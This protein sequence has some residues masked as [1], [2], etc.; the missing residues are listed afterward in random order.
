[1]PMYN[2][3]EY[4]D[5]YSIASGNLWN[6]FREE[7]DGVDNIATHGKSFK[8]K[9][10]NNYKTPVRPPQCGNPRDID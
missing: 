7:I 1:M 8:Y 6:Y 3:L 9:T 2:L 4:S 10:K 5:D